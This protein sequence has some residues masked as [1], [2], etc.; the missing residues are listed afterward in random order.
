MAKGTVVEFPT[1]RGKAS[2]YAMA[3]VHGRGRPGI[4]V[5]QEWW[6]L[7]PH[8]RD[9]VNRFALEGYD[10]LAVDLYHGTSRRCRRGAAPDGRARL[11][12]RRRRDWRRGR[13]SAR[14]DHTTRVG[15]VGFCMGGALAV[16]SAR[17]PGVSAYASFYGFPP[18]PTKIWD[19]YRARRDLCSA[20]TRTSSRSRMRRPLP[21]VSARR[22]LTRASWST[23]RPA[24]RSSTTPA[25]RS[26][27]AMRRR[28]RGPR[29]SCS[30][31]AGS[32]TPTR[33]I[34][35]PSGGPSSGA[36]TGI[37]E[38]SPPSPGA[39]PP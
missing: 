23:R 36:R 35:S 22:R 9:V 2:G 5:I 4:V 3:M 30:S 33:P 32:R 10:A 34:R 18:D 28:P 14:D 12:P 26:T 6:G 8:I 11:G 13:L 17:H 21:S 27:G 16:L 37:P 15:V 29:P 20:S 24:T 31:K 39:T 19:D 7:V 38:P 25:P 1:S